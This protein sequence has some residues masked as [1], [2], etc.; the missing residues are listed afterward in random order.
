MQLKKLEAAV[1]SRLLERG[2]RQLQL[3]DDGQTL[4][5]YARRMLDLHAEAQAALQ[6]ESL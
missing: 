4:L 2:T 1:G 3:T 6:G 5:G